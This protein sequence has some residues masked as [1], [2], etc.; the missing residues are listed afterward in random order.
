M[1]TGKLRTY[2]RIYPCTSFS[3]S[4]FCVKKYRVAVTDYMA[5]GR[6]GYDVLDDCKQLVG[7]EDLKRFDESAVRK[8]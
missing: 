6:D 3:A 2:K 5:D 7:S 1:K 4:R 8:S